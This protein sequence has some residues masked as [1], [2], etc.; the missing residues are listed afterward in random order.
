MTT[1]SLI[2]AIG[3]LPILTTIVALTFTVVLLRRYRARGGMHHLWWA[4]GTFTYA[5][6]TLTESLTTLLGWHEPVFRAWYITGALLGGAPLAQGTVYLLFSRRVANRLTLLLV[7]VILV[8]ATC[9]V[10]SPIDYAAV[11]THRLTGRVLEWRWVRMFS[12]FINLY[13]VIFLI[14]GAIISA[15][16]YRTRR[17]TYHRYVGNLLI[18]VGAILPGIGGTFTRFGHTEVLYVTELIGLLLIYAGFRFNTD[19]GV[20]RV[21]VPAG[22]G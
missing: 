6:G 11:E 15:F 8:A 10:L 7:T 19:P 5:A 18:A 12:P 22:T 3:Y 17:D 21:T 20:I 13:A 1:N 14:G 2:D 9:V 4:I 16:R